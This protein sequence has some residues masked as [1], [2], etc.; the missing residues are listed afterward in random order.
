MELEIQKWV[1]KFK[2]FDEEAE[3]LF[4]EGI[5]CYKVG[6]NKAAFI[7]SYLA[8]EKT[9][10]NRILSFKGIPINITAEKWEETRK[11]I[12]DEYYWERN[13]LNEIKK[14]ME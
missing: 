6:A 7:M 5:E 10:Q 4:N 3:E 2:P 14:I 1:K 8:Y 12:D 11:N 9:I 13:I